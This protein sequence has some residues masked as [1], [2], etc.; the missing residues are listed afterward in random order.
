[1]SDYYKQRRMSP[2][3]RDAAIQD[4]ALLVLGTAAAVTLVVA[5]EKTKQKSQSVGRVLD[6]TQQTLDLDFEG[7]L[8]FKEQ[9]KLRTL[10][11]KPMS[12]E[13]K[14][15]LM[16]YGGLNRAWEDMKRYYQRRGPQF[17]VDAYTG[18]EYPEETIFEV[19]KAHPYTGSL[20]PLHIIEGE[21]L[22]HAYQIIEGSI[23]KARR[24]GYDI[25]VFQ[26]GVQ[27]REFVNHAGTRVYNLSG[28]N[29]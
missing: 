27:L 14:E 11:P 9:P 25:Y 6:D 29:R 16:Q 17:Y 22:A 2:K 19:Y 13:E 10:G 12:Q 24:L 20:I 23:E 7:E 15:H 26:N 8:N 18:D 5:S 3:E 28:C 4:I 1:M 21:E